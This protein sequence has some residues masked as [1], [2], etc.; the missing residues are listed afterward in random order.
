MPSPFGDTPI[1]SPGASPFGDTPHAPEQPKA[2]PFGDTPTAPDSREIKIAQAANDPTFDPVQVYAS[3]DPMSVSQQLN[4][5]SQDPEEPVFKQAAEE[6]NRMMEVRQFAADVLKHKLAMKEANA[7]KTLLGKVGENAAYAGDVALNLVPHKTPEGEWSSG[8]LLHGA[9]AVVDMVAA[10]PGAAINTVVQGAGDLGLIDKNSPAYQ[11]AALKNY[12]SG[13]GVANSLYNPITGRAAGNI[14]AVG[15]ELGDWL[16]GGPKTDAEIH[17]YLESR[18]ANLQSRAKTEEAMTG[19]LKEVV[20]AP[21]DSQLTDESRAIKEFAQTNAEFAVDP[22]NVAFLGAGRAMTGIARAATPAIR[23]AAVSPVVIQAKNLAA[24]AASKGVQGFGKSINT[25]GNIGASSLGQAATNIA[26][27]ALAG[28]ELGSELAGAAAGAILGTK[29]HGIAGPLWNSVSR[30]GGALEGRGAEL[31][32][33]FIGPVRPPGTP[34]AL[35]KIAGNPLAKNALA[36][37]IFSLPFLAI[38]PNAEEAA[39]TLGIGAAFGVLGGLSSKNYNYGLRQMGQKYFAELAP[40]R[41]GMPAEVN[42]TP[43]DLDAL[44]ERAIKQL[45][46]Q[47]QLALQSMRGFLPGA[48][49]YALSPH[50]LGQ[51]ATQAGLPTASGI[52]DAPQI[53]TQL[54]IGGKP[55]TVILLNAG[56]AALNHESGHFIW[57]NLTPEQ[58]GKLTNQVA[59]VD[60]KILQDAYLKYTLAHAKAFNFQTALPKNALAIDASG[61][62]VIDPS[63]KPEEKAAVQQALDYWNSH[64]DG[65]VKEYI[66]ENFNDLANRKGGEKES[67]AGHTGNKS[68]AQEFE[69]A[70]NSVKQRLGGKGRESALGFQVDTKLQDQM[71]AVLKDLAAQRK[72]EGIITPSQPPPSAPGA[73]IPPVSSIAPPPAAGAPIAAPTASASTAEQTRVQGNFDDAAKAGKTLK[74]NKAQIQQGLESAKR[75]G[76]TETED[77]VKRMVNPGYYPDGSNILPGGQVESALPLANIEGAIEQGKAN[78]AALSSQAQGRDPNFDP[79]VNEVI[80]PLANETLGAT[81]DQIEALKAKGYTQ[82]QID[83][84]QPREIEAILGGQL[85]NI[86]VQSG[87]GLKASIDPFARTGIPSKVPPLSASGGLPIV[88]LRQ[89]RDR[90]VDAEGNISQGP[91]KKTLSGRAI[92]INDPAEVKLANDA[93]RDS[94]NPDQFENNLNAVQDAIASGREINF[95]YRSSKSEVEGSPTNKERDEAQELSDLGL[96]LREAVQKTFTPTNFEVDPAK[97]EPVF[98]EASAQNAMARAAEKWPNRRANW[99]LSAFRDLSEFNAAAME[100]ARASEEGRPIQGLNAK[101]IGAVRD[102]L[103]KENKVRFLIKGYS[104]DKVIANAKNLSEAIEASGLN[105][106]PQV[107]RAQAYLKSGEWV[108]DLKDRNENMAHGYRGDGQPF[109]D[110]RGIDQS[111]ARRGSEGA[112]TPKIIPDERIQVLN[113]LEGGTSGKY[114]PEARENAATAGRDPVTGKPAQSTNPLQAKLESLGKNLFLDRA[115]RRIEGLGD[116]VSPA[117]ETLRLD[118][119]EDASGQAPVELPPSNYAQR[120]A[121][122]MPEANEPNRLVNESD[123]T[124]TNQ[125]AK[126]LSNLGFTA[127]EE[128]NRSGNVRSGGRNSD[129]GGQEIDPYTGTRPV[130]PEQWL[131]SYVDHL[132]SEAGNGSYSGEGNQSLLTHAENSGSLVPP[133]KVE[134]LQSFPGGSGVEHDV[135]FPPTAKG[136]TQKVYKITKPGAHGFSGDEISYVKYIDNL[137]KLTGGKLGGEILGVAEQ[138]KVEDP[139]VVDDYLEEGVWPGIVTKWNYI[140]GKVP[141]PL[142]ESKLKNTYGFEKTGLNEWT[143]K[144]TGVVLK[145]AHKSNFIENSKGKLI[146]IDVHVEGDVTKPMFMPAA[147]GFENKS[148]LR[149][150]YTPGEPVRHRI[151]GWHATLAEPDEIISILKNGLI[152]GKREAPQGWPGEYSGKGIY[153]HQR[154]PGHELENGLADGIPSTALIELKDNRRWNELVPDEEVGD[155]GEL[156]ASIR[157]GT[158]IA[159]GGGFDAGSIKNIWLPDVPASHEIAKEIEKI[160]EEQKIIVPPIIFEKKASFM[161]ETENGFDDSIDIRKSYGGIL[162]GNGKYYSAAIGEQGHG[163]AYDEIFKEYGFP[164]KDFNVFDEINAVRI[165]DS[166]GRNTIYAESLSKKPISRDQKEWLLNQAMTHGRKLVFDSGSNSREIYDPKKAEFM[167]ESEPI[168]GEQRPLANAGFGRENELHEE[169]QPANPL[170][171]AEASPGNNPDR[172]AL[173]ARELSTRSKAHYRQFIRQYEPEARPF[174]GQFLKSTQEELHSLSPEDRRAAYEDLVNKKLQGKGPEAMEIAQ[175]EL[176]YVLPSEGENAS[177]PFGLTVEEE[178][179][180]FEAVGINRMEESD[181][182]EANPSHPFIDLTGESL[183]DFELTPAQSELVVHPVKTILNKLTEAKASSELP[184]TL[185]AAELGVTTTNIESEHLDAFDAHF[186][187]NQ[188]VLK[189]FDVDK[190]L[191]GQGIYLPENLRRLVAGEK[192]SYNRGYSEQGSGSVELAKEHMQADIASHGIENYMVQKRLDLDGETPESIAAGETILPGEMRVHVWCDMKGEPHVIPYA[193]FDKRLADKNNHTA[194]GYST[195]ATKA[196]EKA[197]YKAIKALPLEDR[198]GSFFGP[199]IVRL[200]DGSYKPVELNPTYVRGQH[201]PLPGEEESTGSASGYAGYPTAMAAIIA[202]QRGELPFHAQFA[203]EQLEATLP[204]KQW[205]QATEEEMALSGAQF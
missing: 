165:V 49:I 198:I 176:G 172:Q 152:P 16:S 35:S 175:G 31:A 55:Q 168:E 59:Q 43:V 111:E 36:G 69:D 34:G 79:N 138:S 12:A 159:V 8:G 158:P 19:A 89:V 191:Q 155:P 9:E 10:A 195:K 147:E 178:A 194:F 142:F 96:S 99:N 4:N 115:G 51:V 133:V 56:L 163:K 151:S 196:A 127:R 75:D 91:V 126:A 21:E 17:R 26:F 134:R 48:Q 23:A 119:V 179:P 60:P 74:L 44:H 160:A 53:T 131:Q 78:A 62:P 139:W 82:A 106:D 24:Q 92:N 117:S 98:S 114:W 46:P 20:G 157:D 37:A 88:G 192:A 129:G 182:P 121:G 3:V 94:G 25:V 177:G 84:M 173:S 52:Y 171:S 57:D 64:P 200:K 135:Y 72:R 5:P 63:L 1:S 85:G 113:V 136:Q 188:W 95:A 140:P 70:F 67:L 144:D 68:L 76:L 11:T 54:N 201:E 193:T 13:E 180:F 83:A 186:G 47:Q 204:K 167:P 108:Q 124:H 120:A 58:Q 28:K 7:P 109:L 184:E 18:V 156:A 100:V 145:D 22:M 187:K 45:T 205:P 125:H 146:P 32:P 130:A 33:D 101:Q 149:E 164:A 107:A 132:S 29:G 71:R 174:I 14:R 77:I 39:N 81:P 141:G 73:P 189:P 61:N 197:A 181:L 105:S 80:K 86:R 42:G 122:F 137:N 154:F 162:L 143:H 183:K 118:R 190:S 40:E 169:N 41:Y 199:D 15:Q 66:A 150:R 128:T 203:L 2:S 103:E 93:A 97:L 170:N 202:F 166:K 102:L 153:I 123:F 6:F 185:S 65:L 38:A 30:A 87:Q 27:G 110:S 50:D 148:S 112:P 104:Q 116:I 161:P 90:I